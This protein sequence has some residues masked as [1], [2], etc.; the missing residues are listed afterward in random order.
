MTCNEFLTGMQSRGAHCAPACPE[1]NIATTNALLQGL[2]A[3][4]LPTQLIE[5]YRTSGGII[6][7]AGYILGPCEIQRGAAYPVPSIIDV[8]SEMKHISALRGKTIFGRNDLFFFAF[9]AFGAFYMLDNLSLR[10]LR[11][12]DDIYRAM[13][14]CLAAGKL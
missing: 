12:Y 1:R 6:N 14:D 11:K 5:F 8:N 9:D 13:T 3:A 10:P 4:M 2:Q 7:G